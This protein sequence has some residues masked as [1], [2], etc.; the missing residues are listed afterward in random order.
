[1]KKPIRGTR[2]WAVANVDCCTGCTHDCRYCYARYD[3]VVKKGQ[4]SSEE[5]KECLVRESD[6][7]KARPLYPGQVMF[8][9]T[10]DILPENLQPCIQVLRN[11]LEAGN[12]VLVVSKPHLECVR[13]L[14]KE[15]TDYKDKLLFRF[16]I[17]A[18]DKSVL[19]F[20]EPG[21]PAY[22]ERKTSL[23]YAFDQG[24]ETSVSVEPMLD[25]SDVV[26][27]VREL[28]PCVTHS[29]WLG[30]MNKIDERVQ[31]DSDT[32]VLFVE[33]IKAG[34]VD[35]EILLIYKEL[36]D[37]PLIRWK[38][39]IKTVVGVELVSEPGLDI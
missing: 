15:F 21:A 30:K 33:R 35:S 16:T 1:M 25:T 34:Q 26:T 23:C 8:P 18:R 39:S 9:T 24:F 38:E 2:E 3:A 22:S 5:W 29:I 17:T 7:L 28:L 10:H 13:E 14:C 4:L 31:I 32:S 36:Q 37:E 27:M 12:Q 19:D 6:V 11:L 20:W